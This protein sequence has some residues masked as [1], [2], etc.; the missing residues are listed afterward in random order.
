MMLKF[1]NHWELVV[2]V[3]LSAQCTDK[4]INEVTEKLFKKYKTLEDYCAADVAE[5]ERDIFQT[6]FYKQKTK[7]LLAAA[8]MLRE[9]FGGVVPRTMKELMELSGV[10]R[11]TANVVLGNAFGIVVGIAV[12]THVRRLARVFGLSAHTAPEKIEQDLMRLIPP[13]D[14]FRTTYLFIEYGRAFCTARRHA[15]DACPI[16]KLLKAHGD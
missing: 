1:S 9:K 8:K 13:E 16:T 10:G 6:G 2:A 11:K 15:H 3:S 5:F 12:D 7:H 4:K 14:W